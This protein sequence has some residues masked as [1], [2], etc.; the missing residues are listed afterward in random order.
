MN[1]ID[2]FPDELRKKFLFLRWFKLTGYSIVLLSV[3]LFG[4]FFLL[5]QTNERIDQQI[6]SFQMQREITTAWG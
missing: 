5:R 6:Q 2:L 3:V 4:V 1:E